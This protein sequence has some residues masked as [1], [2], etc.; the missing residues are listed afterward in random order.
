MKAL[1]TKMV[2]VGMMVG[3]LSP[4]AQAGDDAIFGVDTSMKMVTGTREAPEEAML[5]GNVTLSPKGEVRVLWDGVT[6]G[7]GDYTIGQ[8]GA[9]TYVS[10]NLPA[11]YLDL[12]KIFGV[13]WMTA[14]RLQLGAGSYQNDPITGRA[15]LTLGQI[16]VNLTQTVVK[17]SSVQ[18]T[19]SESLSGAARFKRKRYDSDQAF[20]AIPVTFAL[21]SKLVANISSEAVVAIS[22]GAYAG[23][24]N[25][26]SQ[27]GGFRALLAGGSIAPSLSIGKHWELGGRFEGT[28][29]IPSFESS[30]GAFA[31]NVSGYVK[32]QFTSR[33]GKLR[34]ALELSV[35]GIDD[36]ILTTASGQNT[37]AALVG[38]KYGVA[39]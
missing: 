16:A 29:M 38:I 26:V 15:D 11:V 22:V 25:G 36:G 20:D 24:V 6:A 9:R 3:G 39:F 27:N 37:R 2:A 30:S 28:E 21:N 5:I 8:A 1:M 18:W 17:T 35:G 34:H 23:I 31:F 14:I 7:L 10:A 13:D 12:Q 19:V 33:Q 32:Y 4:V